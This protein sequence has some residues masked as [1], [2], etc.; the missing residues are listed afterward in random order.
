MKLEKKLSHIPPTKELQ[1]FIQ[2]INK[3][4]R[5]WRIQ[6][7]LKY[8]PTYSAHKLIFSSAVPI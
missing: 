6:I 3:R 5:I 8:N 7:I 4:L 2:H 1:E